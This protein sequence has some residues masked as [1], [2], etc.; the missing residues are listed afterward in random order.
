MSGMLKKGKDS[1]I[2]RFKFKYVVLL[3]NSL[4]WFPSSLAY[5]DYEKEN[6]RSLIF[7][8]LKNNE[9]HAFAFI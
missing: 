4:M 3:G 8:Y 2:S 9:F 1:S 7:L 5:A 6:V